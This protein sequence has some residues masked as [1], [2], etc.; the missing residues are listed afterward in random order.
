MKRT[1]T[2]EVEVDRYGDRH[3][4]TISLSRDGKSVK[5]STDEYFAQN[6]AHKCISATYLNLCQNNVNSQIKPNFFLMASLK[7][8]C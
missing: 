3:C 5:N 7:A 4:D 8:K 1:V 6:I 2:K